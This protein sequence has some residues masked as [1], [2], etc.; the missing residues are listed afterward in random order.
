MGIDV[1]ENVTNIG[2]DDDYYLPDY[3]KELVNTTANYVPIDAGA[4]EGTLSQGLAAFQ[5][6]GMGTVVLGET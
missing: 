2:L 4:Y 6:G 3:Y 1:A 5:A